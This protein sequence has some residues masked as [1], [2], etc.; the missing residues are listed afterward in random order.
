MLWGKQ[1]CSG[2]G[3]GIGAEL[4]SPV[5]VVHTRGESRGGIGGHCI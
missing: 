3:H 4:I 1:V 5:S 2:D